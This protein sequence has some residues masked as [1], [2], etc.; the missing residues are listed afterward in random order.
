MHDWSLGFLQ[1]SEK[2]G[3]HK[4]INYFSIKNIKEMFD[5]GQLGYNISCSMWFYPSKESKRKKIELISE[6]Y[7]GYE[8]KLEFSFKNAHKVYFLE[9]ENIRL[10]KAKEMKEFKPEKEMF[11]TM[12][13]QL[14]QPPRFFAREIQTNFYTSPVL[15]DYGWKRIDNFPL[16]MQNSG[17]DEFARLFL[18]NNTT[19]KLRFKQE[20]RVQEMQLRRRVQ[21][22]I[23]QN[24]Q[25]KYIRDLQ[26]KLDNFGIFVNSIDSKNIFDTDEIPL[27]YYKASK[28]QERWL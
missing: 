16:L 11:Y 28:Y 2:K 26:E 9:E 1:R 5:I 13:F 3:L 21:E 6:M 19:L 27:C 4:F 7:N 8:L 10:V 23:E 17:I 22:S 20:N 14:L 18:I 25:A 15:Q 12:M 24:I